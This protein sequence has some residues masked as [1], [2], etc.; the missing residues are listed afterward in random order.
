VPALFLASS[1]PRRAE[2]LTLLGF[3]FQVLKF[4]LPEVRGVQESPGEYGVR[5]ALEK[6]R[7]GL[8]TLDPI[9]V[10]ADAVVLG[11]D[12]EVVLADRV[13][14]KPESDAHAAQMLQALSGT[15]HQVLTALAVVGKK[16][17]HT[18][19]HRS[20]VTFKVLSSIDIARYLQS[21]EHMGKAGAY[22]VQGRAAAFISKLDGSHYSVMGLPVF[23]SAQLLAEFGVFPM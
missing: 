2:L 11:A 12:T 13:F 5:V 3:A 4:E 21:G 22:A 15:S 17:E 10:Q 8:A 23:E 6:A 9:T 18:L 16:R 19:L 7:A 14:G 1:S 20:V